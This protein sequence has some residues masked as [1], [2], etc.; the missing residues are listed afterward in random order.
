MKQWKTVIESLDPIIARVDFGNN[1]AEEIG[2]QFP[3]TLVDL[4]V[5]SPLEWTNTQSHA[6]STPTMVW[7]KQPG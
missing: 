1:L 7:T 2:K 4:A 5:P 3:G 6:L